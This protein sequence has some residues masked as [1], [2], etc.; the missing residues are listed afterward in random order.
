MANN[1]PVIPVAGVSSADLVDTFGAARSGDRTH[2]GIDI[3]A[4]MGTPVISAVD[5]VVLNAGDSG[6][7]GGLRVWVQGTDGRF[8][9]YAHLSGIN[10]APGQR[11]VAGQP[12]GTVG[13]TGNAK[14]T[15]PH[16][17]YSVN[18]TS[19]AE[20]GDV[21]PYSYL[22]GGVSL[23]DMTPEQL[24]MISGL[25]SHFS[26]QPGD[27]SFASDDDGPI[28]M[29]AEEPSIDDIVNNTIE[30][31][32]WMSAGG[33]PIDVES[34]IAPIDPMEEVQEEVAA[35][36]GEWPSPTGNPNAAYTPGNTGNPDRDWI[37]AKESDGIPTADN[38]KSTAFGIGQL[39]EDNRATYAGRFGFDPN[40]TDPWQQIQ[41]M[42]A[43]VADRYGSYAAARQFHEQNGWY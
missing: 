24:A 4:P 22:Q 31:M 9:Y 3:F 41:M 10:V 30:M 28:G 14:G 25:S 2:K 43:Y 37:I 12:L 39:L 6:G 7:L 11:V 19:G 17:H 13:D 35:P 32:S 20:T 5:G 26:W 38:P 15:S 33:E 40:T 8:H 27:L 16:L 23:A 36:T 42:D 34:F 21:N 1:S 18:S 29:V